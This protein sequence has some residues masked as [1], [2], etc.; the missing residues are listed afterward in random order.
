MFYYL[1]TTAKEYKDIADDGSKTL[2]Y[3]L[4]SASD[5]IENNGGKYIVIQLIDGVSNANSANGNWA[6]LVW[7]T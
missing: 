6:K 5:S 3:P 1:A 4:S 7:E 2:T